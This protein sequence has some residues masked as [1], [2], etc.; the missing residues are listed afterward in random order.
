MENKREKI[1]IYDFTIFTGVVVLLSY[2]FVIFISFYM[3]VNKSKYAIIAL[4]LGILFLI[5]FFVVLSIF[6]FLAPYL[7]SKGAH[8][9]KK[10]ISINKIKFRN[11]YNMRYR[12]EQIVIED[13]YVKYEKMLQKE[14]DKQ[15]I[16]VQNTKINIKKINKYMKKYDIK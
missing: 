1:R 16:K 15:V 12:E 10:F 9:G 13:R 5:S 3:W 6:V 7:D 14:I 2:S 11:S 8:Q 4:I